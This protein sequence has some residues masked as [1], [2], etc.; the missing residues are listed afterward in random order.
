MADDESVFEFDTGSVIAFNTMPI[1]DGVVVT[2]TDN[3]FPAESQSFEFD[4][5][6]PADLTLP[7]ATRIEFGVGDNADSLADKLKDAI[8]ANGDLSIVATQVGPRVSLINDESIS[9]TLNG[10][11]YSGDAVRKEGA[12]GGSAILHI[13]DPS[14]LQDGDT[15][16]VTDEFFS[17]TTWEFNDVTNP[18]AG[19]TPGNEQIDFDPAD[20]PLTLASKV[21]LAIM[22]NTINT[23][24]IAHRGNDR[25]AIIGPETLSGFGGFS[26]T[27]LPAAA[28]FDNPLLVEAEEHWDRDQVAI[29]VQALSNI[30][31]FEIGA[32]GDR[33]NFLGAEVGD[34]SGVTPWID[35]LSSGGVAQQSVN[36]GLLAHDEGRDYADPFD[37]N[38]PPAI[39]DGIAT[40]IADAINGFFNG[41]VVE[42]DAN[43]DNVSIT[44]AIIDVSGADG[45]NADGNGGPGGLIKGM[46]GLKDV[47][48][49]T[50]SLFAVSD[51]GGLYQIFLGV[52]STDTLFLV[53]NFVESSKAD[54]NG[55]NFTGLTAGPQNLEDGRYADLLFGIDEDHVVYAF[56]TA[57]ELQPVFADGSTTI[58][59]DTFGSPMAFA[60][61]PVGLIFGNLDTNLF[62]NQ[63]LVD[64]AATQQNETFRFNTQLE[65]YFETADLWD[66][67]RIT[68]ANQDPNV[69]IDKRQDDPGHGITPSPDGT[70]EEALPGHTSLHFGRGHVGGDPRS[71]DY[72]GGAH[73]TM[74]SNEFSLIGK[75][76]ADKPT[77]YFNYFLGNEGNDTA[78]ISISDNG[79]EWRP[80]T[81][82]ANSN[83]SWLQRRVDLS[84]YA[85][86]EHLRLR[87]DFS[88]SAAV[89]NPDTAGSELR[90]IEGRYLRDGDSFSLDAQ[91][92]LANIIIP[93][94]GADPFEL[95]GPITLDIDGDLISI[96]NAETI[97]IDFAA[98]FGLE[99][100][101]PVELPIDGTLVSVTGQ[102]HEFESGFT[103]V[104]PSGGA[105]EENSTFDVE[106]QN[107]S[108]STFEF[109]SDAATVTP[110]NVHIQFDTTDSAADIASR[111]SDAIEAEF[112]AFDVHQNGERVNYPVDRAGNGPQLFAPSGTTP[113][114]EEFIEGQAGLNF[115]LEEAPP[116]SL[117]LN[118]HPIFVHEGM[119]RTEV[120]DE[121]NISMEPAVYNP[122]LVVEGGVE[123]QD[124]ETFILTDGVVDPITN[125]D[126]RR[127][128][129]F[130]AGFVV[131]IPTDGA[132]GVA[133][134]DLLIIT[135]AADGTSATF[136]FDNDATITPG[137]IQV[138]YV[139]TSRAIDL[140]NALTDA[141][142]GSGPA[143]WALNAQVIDGPRVQIHSDLDTLNI[144]ALSNLIFDA[145]SV[146][147]VGIDLEVVSSGADLVDGDTIAF[148]I[149]GT[150]DTTTTFE[151][152]F[153]GGVTGTN[154]PVAVNLTDSPEAIAQAL[155]T[156][157]G[158]SFTSS[159]LEGRF[160]RFANESGL[161]VDSS[162][163][164]P[165]AGFGGAGV[166]VRD[167]EPVRFIPGDMNFASDIAVSVTNAI[168]ATSDPLDIQASDPSVTGAAQRRIALTHTSLRPIDIGFTDN[169][170]GDIQL[171]MPVGD[172]TNDIV[173]QHNDMLR[174]VGHRVTD[175]GP[176]GLAVSLIG[177]RDV[178]GLANNDH[179]GLYLDDFVIGF[180]ER[181][182]MVTL[183]TGN[184]AY[185]GDPVGVSLGEYQL[186][187][188]RAS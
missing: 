141:I 46:A 85:G 74:V 177:D 4:N 1:E 10:V 182:E 71:Y 187:I 77:M 39:L 27:A 122:V 159:V 131:D 88:T 30:T 128:Y 117:N 127:V 16:S 120:A 101:N 158:G 67:A 94:P 78:L 70:R 34:F 17:V 50:D 104:A 35:Q 76:P 62:W 156:A 173:K 109:A 65:P 96:V 84:N 58:Q 150:P 97:A 154:I 143:T 171:E 5:S 178:A 164:T 124:G 2:V 37:L 36:I 133:D 114:S 134:G 69:L 105:I 31:P 82:L 64:D 126:S 144:D 75:S 81:S 184:S 61:D 57:G 175:A 56:N 169:T 161:I 7:G 29:S 110:G 52:N 87:V 21:E 106:D 100:E 157:L 148:T 53:E 11:N 179:E 135:N 102:F 103:F 68:V 92:T 162:L 183:G 188:R 116:V 152:D 98:L 47:R 145:N 90:A 113:I 139:S 23:G 112:P 42:A 107:G 132:L 54:L 49:R 121:I 19:V 80:L 91:V 167:H 153:G 165:P 79:G 125:L 181:G 174:I 151:F 38:V 93:I 137:N 118:P 170:G 15:F 32:K 73:G 176:I 28:E 59:L 6:D 3:Q 155:D 72:L 185:D 55:I 146:P 180:A 33:L 51:N 24:Y 14:Q 60:G 160:L 115:D 40:K 43:G 9:I 20:T 12:A 18:G 136:E 142:N 163:T 140:A 129:E 22:G 111:L 99:L 186:E 25:I 48:G 83:G 86:I 26:T 8:N 44:G 108:L 41:Q 138:D 172:F 166:M 45:L 149:P 147:G 13:K 66:Q 168:N 63:I 130:E 89:V 95:P 119:T 123:Y